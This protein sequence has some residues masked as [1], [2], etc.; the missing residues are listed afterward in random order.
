VTRRLTEGELAALGLTPDQL[1]E[2]ATLSGDD[3]VAKGASAALALPEQL[4]GGR[5][6]P[7]SL[8]ILADRGIEVAQLDSRPSVLRL[9][10]SPAPAELL[11]AGDDAQLRD[12]DD[13]KTLFLDT[14]RAGLA[15]LKPTSGPGLVIAGGEG[16]Q[17]L[18]FPVRAADSAVGLTAR[19]PWRE[20]LEGSSD[21]WL[22]GE[23]ERRLESGDAWLDLTCAG[24]I[25]RL[26]DD[27]FGADPVDLARRLASGDQPEEL[28]RVSGW[29]RDLDESWIRTASESL[30]TRLSLLAHRLTTLAAWETESDDEWRVALADFLRQRDDVECVWTLLRIWQRRNGRE[31]DGHASSALS[32]LDAEAA[33]FVRSLRPDLV[34][35]DE[36]LARAAVRAPECWWVHPLV[37][38]SG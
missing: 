2:P 19:L 6:V 8:P 1:G 22:R 11:G 37:G 14:A 15:H 10:S 28:E 16:G 25:H 20:W 5:F 7:L 35:A 31:E 3:S 29:I 30:E 12:P 17:V 26:L 18:L 27:S 4:A 13:E 23:V 33:P 34:Q 32:A 36:Q 38:R 24:L 9:V 21:E